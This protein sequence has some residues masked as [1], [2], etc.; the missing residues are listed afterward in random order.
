MK[1]TKKLGYFS[2]N[3][4]HFTLGPTAAHNQKLTL[5]PHIHLKA[6]CMLAA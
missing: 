5:L 1:E 6:K 2:N 4:M 3:G